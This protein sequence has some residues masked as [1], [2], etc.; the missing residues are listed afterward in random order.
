MNKK[1]RRAAIFALTAAM[2]LGLSLGAGCGGKESSESASSETSFH[3]SS[4]GETSHSSA[5]DSSEESSECTVSITEKNASVTL[6]DKDYNSYADGGKV[7]KGTQLVLEATADSHTENLV[8]KLNGETVTLTDGAYEFTADGAI[9]IEAA[10][11]MEKFAVTVTGDNI[12][13]VITDENEKTYRNGEEIEYGKNVSFEISA[14][15]NYIIDTISINGKSYAPDALPQLDIEGALTVN[16]TAIAARTV[17]GRLGET[18]S[19]YANKAGEIFVSACEGK[20]KADAQL[21]EESGTL[22]YSLKVPSDRDVTVKVD[23][24]LFVAQE[25]SVSAGSDQATADLPLVPAA[26][27][28]LLQGSGGSASYA[29]GTYSVRGSTENSAGGWAA[30]LLF[31]GV[32]DQYWVMETKVKNVLGGAYAQY[33]FGF[34]VG[35]RYSMILK[36]RDIDRFCAT[37]WNSGGGFSTQTLLHESQISRFDAALGK[38]HIG[39][40]GSESEGSVSLKMIR[41]NDDLYLFIDGLYAGKMNYSSWSASGRGSMAFGFAVRSGTS[42]DFYDY[43]YETG[44]TA[45]QEELEELKVEIVIEGVVN[46]SVTAENTYAGGIE[47]VSSDKETKLVT[48]RGGLVN[49]GVEAE[50][51]YELASLTV[52][53]TDYR[54][55]SKTGSFAFTAEDDARIRAEFV[56]IAQKGVLSVNFTATGEIDY[57][58]VTAASAVS[59]LQFTVDESGKAEID[60]M[61]PGT[62]DVVFSCKGYYPETRKVTIEAGGTPSL[63]IRFDNAILQHFKGHNGW[64]ADPDVAAGTLETKDVSLTA[65]GTYYLG[66]CNSVRFPDEF[67]LDDDFV[68]EVTAWKNDRWKLLVGPGLHFYGANGYLRDIQFGWRKGTGEGKGEYRVNICDNTARS[69][70]RY[71]YEGGVL[72]TLPEAFG[73]PD[74]QGNIRAT[75]MRIIKNGNYIYYTI[76]TVGKAEKEEWVFASRYLLTDADFAGATKFYA[77]VSSKDEGGCAFKDTVLYKEKSIVDEYIAQAKKNYLCTVSTTAEGSAYGSYEVAGEAWKNDRVKFEAKPNENGI[78]RLFE[79][80]GKDH[81]AELIENNY[82]YYFDVSGNT[83]IKIIFEEKSELIEV[84]GS[85]DCGAYGIPKEATIVNLTVGGEG[86]YNPANGSYT[87]SVRKGKT[88][89]V[90]VAPKGFAAKVVSVTA[91]DETYV[92]EEQSGFMPSFTASAYNKPGTAPTLPYSYEEGSY[93]LAGNRDGN[94]SGGWQAGYAFDNVESDKWVVEY[95]ATFAWGGWSQYK[96]GFLLTEGILLII[97]DRDIRIQFAQINGEE[98]NLAKAFPLAQLQDAG[99]DLWGNKIDGLVFEDAFRASWTDDEYRNKQGETALTPIKLKLVRNGYDIYLFIN[100]EFI[101]RDNFKAY[102]DKIGNAG[103]DIF[104]VAAMSGT[105]VNITGLSYTVN[106][107]EVNAA[108]QEAGECEYSVA[109]ETAGNGKL[110]L[111]ENKAWKYTPVTVEIMPDEGWTLSSLLI[112]GVDCTE[113]AKEGTYTFFITGNTAIK[114]VF[115]ELTETIGARLTVSVKGGVS[116]AVLNVTTGA[117]GTY[118]NGVATVPVRKGKTDVIRI[119]PAG[120]NALTKEILATTDGFNGGEIKGFTLKFT[121]GNISDPIF[122]DAENGKYTTTG[123]KSGDTAG[124]WQSVFTLDGVESDKYVMEYSVVMDWGGWTQWKVGFQISEKILLIIQDRDVRV[125]FVGYGQDWAWTKKYAAAYADDEKLVFDEALTAARTDNGGTSSPI[126]FKV[127]RNGDDVYLFVNG[128]Y[129][130]K[131]SLAAYLV[132]GH[133]TQVDAGHSDWE[134]TAGANKFGLATMSGTK[135]EFTNVSFSIDAADVAAEISE[136]TQA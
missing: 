98:W 60:Y 69:V 105:A 61:L 7:E 13:V 92:I 8:V 68:L 80:N 122:C 36:D 107:E 59:K 124:G 53:G 93:T 50:Y 56:R 74:S 33:Q 81:T 63:D 78:V 119:T 133:Q 99:Q 121:A 86:T 75:R 6:T 16:A 125:G 45:V 110:V 26:T 18:D 17:T 37:A 106:V 54:E 128:A 89:S 134:F 40:A 79:V 14:S 118:E 28:S 116:V 72:T 112:D 5:S 101:A 24:P 95:S 35:D 15:E 70:S 87:V 109:A 47:V 27:L 90:S 115:E 65:E 43:Y 29:D 39:A 77:S 67:A 55:E 41:S 51:S 114:A 58:S 97:E 25:A 10:A 64:S 113:A 136:I 82:L 127:V 108:I 12:S 102:A 52:N 85:I 132:E 30:N 131:E 135:A 44:M 57:A 73:T 19:H 130:G 11:E 76:S 42:A 46:G 94:T 123:S 83:Q 100:D 62:Y 32:Q 49:F 34:A 38:T 104:G 2:A 120:Y 126:K 71:S 22:T 3:S 103:S 20:Y 31:D 9:V 66:V 91:S 48:Y 4:S 1:Q 117:A 88:D 23:S 84:S 129:M 96:A 21:D 111:S